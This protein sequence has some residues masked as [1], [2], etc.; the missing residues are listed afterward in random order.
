MIIGV[1]RVAWERHMRTHTGEKPFLC[2]VC[3]YRLSEHTEQSPH[4]LTRHMMIHTGGKEFMC[5]KCKNQFRHSY[6]LSMHLKIYAGVKPCACS[7]CDYRSV[8]TE[9]HRNGTWIV[10]CKVDTC[11]RNHTVVMSVEKRFN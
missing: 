11:V 9:V 3:D 2:N 8:I 10:T 6:T 5:D 1:H 4:R 7:A